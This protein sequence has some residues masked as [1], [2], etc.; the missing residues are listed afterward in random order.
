MASQTKC[1]GSLNGNTIL[2][3][4]VA[5]NASIP[6]S[7]SLDGASNSIDSSE[8]HALKQPAPMTA[9]DPG[10]TIPANPLP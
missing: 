7:R 3:I 1:R 2:L 9:T 4:L 10:T 6:I 8:Q 5:A